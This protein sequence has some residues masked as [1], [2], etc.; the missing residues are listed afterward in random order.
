MS[1]LKEYEIIEMLDGNQSDFEYYDYDDDENELNENE[2]TYILFYVIF[3]TL[4][5]KK[6]VFLFFIV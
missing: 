3:Y 2:G 6:E 1:S 5:Y 4:T